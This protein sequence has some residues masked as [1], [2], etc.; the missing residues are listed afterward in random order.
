MGADVS[1]LDQIESLGGQ[2][3]RRPGPSYR[4]SQGGDPRRS[5]QRSGQEQHGQAH[6]GD[7]PRLERR[8]QCAAVE[9]VGNAKLLPDASF[10]SGSLDPG[11]ELALRRRQGG[12]GREESRQRAW[13]ELFA[14]DWPD[15]PFAFTLAKRF[16]LLMRSWTRGSCGIYRDPG[17][18]PRCANPFRSEPYRGPSPFLR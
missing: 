6:Q 13:R 17:E 14:Q 18:R 9:V 10:E 2:G 11:W 8:G 16:A 7:D 15:K 3:Q 1:M 4:S 5:R 12:D